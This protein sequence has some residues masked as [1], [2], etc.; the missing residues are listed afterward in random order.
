MNQAALIFAF[1]LSVSIPVFGVA[2]NEN[3]A[4]GPG[5]W[6]TTV[7]GVVRDILSTMKE[8]DRQEVKTHRKMTL[9][10]FTLVGVWG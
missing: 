9:Y 7:N 2:A 6:P 10:S 4:L 3:N 1:M 8:K 5:A